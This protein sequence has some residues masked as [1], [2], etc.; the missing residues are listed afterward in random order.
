MW[1]VWSNWPSDTGSMLCRFWCAKS[2]MSASWHTERHLLMSVVKCSISS[3][4][5]WIRGPNDRCNI[6]TLT[7]LAKEFFLL[8]ILFLTLSNALFFSNNSTRSRRSFSRSDTS[9]YIA[10]VL[11][12]HLRG[13]LTDW[14]LRGGPCREVR[15]FLTGDSP[16][17]SSPLVLDG[18]GECSGRLRFNFWRS[19][20][21]IGLL[22]WLPSGCCLAGVTGLDLD[23]ELGGVEELTSPFSFASSVSSLLLQAFSG[24]GNFSAGARL[25]TAVRSTS[26]E[27]ERLRRVNMQ[28]LVDSKL[29][30]TTQRNHI[31]EILK[32]FWFENILGFSLV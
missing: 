3:C 2:S 10:L 14:M 27:L 13:L 5:K 31:D 8:W 25:G 32:D 20:S 11:L 16:L 23:W 22:R 29:L 26:I 12:F 6:V 7:L 17:N 24:S 28:Y 9:P 21:L 15:C 18:V 1:K 30:E 19:E 4:G